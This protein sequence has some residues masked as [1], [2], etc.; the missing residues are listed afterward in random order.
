MI[1]SRNDK[2]TLARPFGCVLGQATINMKVPTQATSMNDTPIKNIS[3]NNSC[4]ESSPAMIPIV[5]LSV[6]WATCLSGGFFQAKEQRPHVR[7]VRLSRLMLR[8][9]KSEPRQDRR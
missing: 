8:E 4:L 9:V 5:V 7:V 3:L 1:A 6:L 2:G